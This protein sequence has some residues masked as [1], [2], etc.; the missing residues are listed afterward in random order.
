VEALA[1]Q[2]EQEGGLRGMI[3]GFVTSDWYRRAAAFE[4]TEQ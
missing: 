1:E 4:E 3:I 2:A